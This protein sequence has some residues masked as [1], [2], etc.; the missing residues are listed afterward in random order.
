MNKIVNINSMMPNSHMISLYIQ[1]TPFI[2]IKSYIISPKNNL[3]SFGPIDICL[4]VPKDGG[5]L[6]GVSLRYVT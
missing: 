2:V 1:K 4:I 5:V 6:Q 3:Q